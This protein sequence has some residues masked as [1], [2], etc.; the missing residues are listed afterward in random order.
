MDTNRA[1][2]PDNIPTEFYQHCWEV[3][4]DDVMRLFYC[5]HV[6][7]LDVQ[8]LNYGI[9]TLLPKVAEANKIQQFRP[10]CLLRCIYKLITKTLTIRLEPFTPKLFSIQQNA[11]I[12]N[13]NIMD[14][15]FSLHEIM[16]HTHVKKQVGVILNLDI[17]NTKVSSPSSPL[18]S[19]LFNE[20]CLHVSCFFQ[21]FKTVSLGLQE[22]QWK[23]YTSRYAHPLW[24]L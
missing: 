2:G 17:E 7:S 13:R 23:K 1:P 19:A 3:I 22:N 15:I 12:K 16:H 18:I 20:K 24:K 6:G 4:K 9:I 5:F 21:K 8:R 14:R 11:L 10:I